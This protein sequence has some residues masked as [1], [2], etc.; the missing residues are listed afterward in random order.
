[1]FSIEEI[2]WTIFLFVNYR[3]K[4]FEIVVKKIFLSYFWYKV[5][6]KYYLLNI[7]VYILTLYQVQI[8]HL[9]EKN[10]NDENTIVIVSMVAKKQMV[11]LSQQ[12]LHKL[13][14]N[15]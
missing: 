11:F 15:T 4:Y 3:P 9:L 12:L 13:R 10:S 6:F 14:W 5:E 7:Y 2:S 8:S 1:M